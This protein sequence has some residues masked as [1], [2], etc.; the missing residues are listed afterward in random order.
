MSVTPLLEARGLKK[1]FASRAGGSRR[2][3]VALDGVDLALQRR[4]TLAVVGESGSGKSTLGR[5]LLRLVEPSAGEVRF[6][7][8]D[9]LSI[10]GRRL[11]QMRRRF[12]AVFQDPMGS[13]DPRMRVGAALAEPMV[14]HRLLAEGRTVEAVAGLLRRVGLPSDAAARYPHEFSGG[15]RQRIAIARALA[16]DP[17][18]LVADEPVSSLDSSV[19]AQVV[20][21]LAD[22]QAERGLAMLFIAH[23]LV[24][25][26]SM[27]DRVAVMFGGRIVEQGPVPRLFAEPQHP[28]TAELLAAVPAIPPRRS[29]SP[30][31]PAGE[32]PGGA[33]LAVT[34]CAFTPRCP[35]AAPCC[36]ERPPLRA[37]GDGRMVACHFPGSIRETSGVAAAGRNFSPRGA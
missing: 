28:Y 17:D 29:V 5:C 13:L 25:V 19:R 1:V 33:G 8:I 27:A 24:L 16:T 18:L 14:A 34:G 2:E 20:N 3:V 30:A 37:I 32:G 15:Q 11:R 26:E 21:L 23:D 10:D 12:Q 6:D 31:F 35:L 9:I 7:G 4:E 36:A 22:L